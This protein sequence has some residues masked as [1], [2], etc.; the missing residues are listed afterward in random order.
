MVPAAANGSL[1]RKAPIP[2]SSE[3]LSLVQHVELNRAGWWE[4]TIQKLI[5]TAV[6]LHSGTISRDELIT[7]L[8][9]RCGINIDQRVLAQIDALTKAQTLLPFLF[10]QLKLAEQPRIE[11]ERDIHQAEAVQTAAHQHFVAL[12][13]QHAPT[14]DPEHT[15]RIFLATFFEPA[16]KESGAR[17]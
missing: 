17:L 11:L 1:P 6:W 7:D 9:H 3:L 13:G 14:L 12:L 15:W 4:R 2:I 8:R 16:I 5:V 10:Q